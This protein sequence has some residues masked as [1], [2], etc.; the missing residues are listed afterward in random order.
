MDQLAQNSRGSKVQGGSQ[1]CELAL[2]TAR[3]RKR[4]MHIITGPQC[5]AVTYRCASDMLQKLSARLPV[6][7]LC[8]APE[9]SQLTTVRHA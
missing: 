1:R 2:A 6:P 7:I 4:H 3:I 8:L 5:W 9:P